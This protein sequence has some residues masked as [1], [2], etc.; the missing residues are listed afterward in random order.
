MERG[1]KKRRRDKKEMRRKEVRGK[2]E[3]VGGIE[4]YLWRGGRGIEWGDRSVSFCG[5][6]IGV[7]RREEW[8]FGVVNDFGSWL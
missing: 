4:G 5:V 7:E 3:R 8:S 2:R 1:R 6:K